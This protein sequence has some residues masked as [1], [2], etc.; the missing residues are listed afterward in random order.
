MMIVTAGVLGVQKEPLPL[1]EFLSETMTKALAAIL[2]LCL[3]NGL[4]MA[5]VIVPFLICKCVSDAREEADLTAL[6][7]ETALA[8]QERAAMAAGG[9]TVGRVLSGPALWSL[10]DQHAPCVCVV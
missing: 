4:V 7:E 6:R 10:L 8:A 3:S 1:E 2:V 5:C 9:H